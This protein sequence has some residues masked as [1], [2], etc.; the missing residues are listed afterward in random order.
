MVDEYL[1][2]DAGSKAAFFERVIGTAHTAGYLTSYLASWLP[3]PIGIASGIANGL[4]GVPECLEGTTLHRMMG[5]ADQL[6]F[7]LLIGRSQVALLKAGA[8]YGAQFGT[9]AVA[10]AAVAAGGVAK[11]IASW[12]GQ[13]HIVPMYMKGARKGLQ[14]RLTHQ[15]HVDIHRFIDEAGE[16]FNIPKR[17]HGRAAVEQWLRANPS[18]GP[19]QLRIALIEAYNR[20]DAVHGT[21]LTANLFQAIMHQQWLP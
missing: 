14:I 4:M 6:S 11:K 10:G 7:K 9:R 1:A 12:A 15:Q 8:Q 20:F 17:S 13:H 3:G 2:E 18:Q 16:Q 19:I 5:A 21:N